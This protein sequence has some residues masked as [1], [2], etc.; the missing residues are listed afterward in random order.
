MAKRTGAEVER[1]Y[2]TDCTFHWRRVFGMV[3]V[4]ECVFV[5]E[6]VW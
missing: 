1:I 3:C 5:Y 2:L 4:S 6:C